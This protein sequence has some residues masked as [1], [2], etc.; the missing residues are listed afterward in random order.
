MVKYI[1]SVDRGTVISYDKEVENVSLLNHFYV[2]YIWYIPEDGEWIYTKKDGSKE[3]RSV[4]KGT[5]V[6]KLYPI[7]KESDAEYIFVEND[8]VKNH[9]NRLLEKGQEEKRNLLLVILNVIVLVNL[10]S[11]VVNMDKLLIDQYGNAILYKVDTNSIKNVSDNF[12]CRTMYV[13]QQDGQVITEEEVIDYKLGDI[14]LI[15]SKYDS[16]SNK[17]TL[18]PIVCSDAFAKD[19][20]IRWSKEDNKQVLT[21]ETI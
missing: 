20:L 19:D 7:D 12:E 10:Y 17:W 15:L 1:C 18:K 13:A 6:I 4:T 21:N 16:I 2:D 11:V 5:M 3:R 9:Y 8:E 14:V